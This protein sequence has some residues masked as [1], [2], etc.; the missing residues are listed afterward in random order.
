M[1]HCIIILKYYE[2][3]DCINIFHDSILPETE[4]AETVRQ[5]PVGSSASGPALC[6][7]L[8]PWIS[9]RPVSSVGRASDF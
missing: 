3:W 1:C 6:Q 9:E 5:C 2:L 4:W 7:I 8:T